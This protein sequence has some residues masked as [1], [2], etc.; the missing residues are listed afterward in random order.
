MSKAIDVALSAFFGTSLPVAHDSIP[1]SV[2]TST[3]VSCPGIDEVKEMDKLKAII[4]KNMSEVVRGWLR[5]AQD[6]R[7]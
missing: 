5:L 1:N 7:K 4:D 3:P 6:P 2:S